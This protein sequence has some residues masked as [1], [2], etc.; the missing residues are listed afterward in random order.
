[1]AIDARI[2]TLWQQ[3]LARDLAALAL[4]LVLCLL[5]FWPVL[6]PKLEDRGSFRAGDFYVQTYACNTYKARELLSAHFP[7]WNPY[8]YSGHPFLADLQNSPLY[9]PSL[10]TILLS[11]PWGYSV[12]ALELEAIVHFFLA[13]AFAYLLG[14]HLFR[15]RG[16]A[17]LTAVIFTFGGYL[18]SFPPL[19]LPILETAAWLPLILLLLDLGLARLGAAPARG[20]WYC[21]LAGAAFGVALLAG[22]PQTALY[23]FYVA[24][25]WYLFRGVGRGHSRRWLLAGFAA[26]GGAAGGLAAVQL[27][28]GLEL[29]RLS[30]RATAVYQ[31]LSSGFAL[32][33]ILQIVL[34]GVSSYWSPLYV[35]IVPLVWVL[36]AWVAALDG[37]ALSPSREWRRQVTFWTVLAVLALL[38]SFGGETFVYSLFYLIAPGFDL[39]RSQERVSLVFSLSLALLSGYGLRYFLILVTRPAGKELAGAVLNKLILALLA[40]L[41]GLALLLFFGSTQA[42][43]EQGRLM[44]DMLGLVFFVGLLLGGAWLWNAIW[45]HTHW[46]TGL[47]LGLLLALIVFDLFTLNSR[48][49][50]QGRPP[51]RQVRAT[52][53]IQVLQ[54]AD[55]DR[56]FRVYHGGYYLSGNYGC[57]FEVEDI[58]GASQLHLADYARFLAQVPA[59]RAWELLNVR[60][61]VTWQ[62]ALSVPSAVVYHTTTRNGDEVYLHRLQIGAPRA[63]AVFQ[64]KVAAPEQILKQ[65]SLP[66]FEPHRVAL[67]DA[68]LELPLT[69]Q[70]NGQAVLRF[71]PLSPEHLRIEAEMPARGLVVLSELDYPGWQ[72]FLDGRR[73]PIRRAN[74]ILRAV[75][76]PAGVHQIEMRFRP[77]SVYL[78]ATVSVLTLIGILGYTLWVGRCPGLKEPAVKN[79]EVNSQCRR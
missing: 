23:L 8:V 62:A 14:R 36:F 30:I 50:I 21:L 69:E 16:A 39:F 73:V 57:L 6:T 65:L 27:L 18:T 71:T 58:G 77:L 60:Y 40:G 29:M 19:Q 68:P 54:A 37:W 11:A 4:L 52:P 66:D 67:L 10:A 64:T 56:P 76:V 46:R 24:A 74:A 1:M 5:F 2:R 34:P 28:P 59:E 61:V 49:N 51:E 72:A 17:L 26:C 35:G 9:P 31:N 75:E 70:P 20:I 44:A 53:A 43:A 12:L 3:G 42:G 15:Q 79:D 25:A 41:G 47:A 78:G 33:D 13:G 63:W 32:K 45:M 22:H 7:L 38:L 55:V 48:T